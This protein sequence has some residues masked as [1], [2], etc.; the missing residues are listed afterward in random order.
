MAN[1]CY[2]EMRIKG[3]EENIKNLIKEIPVTLYEQHNGETGESYLLNY[4]FDEY[5]GK[6]EL[7]HTVGIA[8]ECRGSMRRTFFDDMSPDIEELCARYNVN[9]EAFSEEEANSFQEHLKYENGKSS[10]ETRNVQYEYEKDETGEDTLTVIAEHGGFKDNNPE[11]FDF[12][13][14]E[15]IVPAEEEMEME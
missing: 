4:E 13:T 2:F 3:E 5:D 6:E 10:Y 11:F 1:V 9:I 12:D 15:D 14:L 8:G 7:Y